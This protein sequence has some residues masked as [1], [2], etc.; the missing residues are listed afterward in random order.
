M[1]SSFTPHVISNPFDLLSSLN[2]KIQL[3]ELNDSPKRC[4]NVMG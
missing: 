4:K 2:K 3:N 1:L